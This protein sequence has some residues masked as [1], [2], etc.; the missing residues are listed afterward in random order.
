MIHKNYHLIL[1]LEYKLG[2][3]EIINVHVSFLVFI[4][5]LSFVLNE[6]QIYKECRIS[7][8]KNVSRSWNINTIN[9][10]LKCEILRN[11]KLD[12]QIA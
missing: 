3:G 10:A 5:F 9:A 2:K 12:I 6:Q 11:F 1:K 4:A 7:V 8:G